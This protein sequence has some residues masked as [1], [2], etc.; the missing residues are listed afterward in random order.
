MNTEASHVGVVGML[1]ILILNV[2]G[3]HWN[4]LSRE[5]IRVDLYF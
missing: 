2:M 3:N 5:M 1:S 4:V